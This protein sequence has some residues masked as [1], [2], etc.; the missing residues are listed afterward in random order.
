MGKTLI[1]A[2]KRSVAEDITK[3]FGGTFQNKKT[4][5]ESD[6]QIVTWAVGHLA[7]L[8]PP[9]QYDKRFEKWRMA[10]LPII[11]E[12]FRVVPRTEGAGKDQLSAILGLLKRK[13]VDFVVNACD[14]GREGELI[15]AYVID[16]AGRPE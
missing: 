5:L 15:F 16:L 12:H 9:E 2:E 4:Y 11:P 8:A 1:I 10:D 13:D 3:A 14:A 6:D 7:E